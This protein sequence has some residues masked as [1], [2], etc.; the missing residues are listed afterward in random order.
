MINV[1]LVSHLSALRIRFVKCYKAELIRI[2]R[3]FDYVC[4]QLNR[5]K[6]PTYS[7]S[8]GQEKSVG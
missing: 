1:R 3:F 4:I 2:F 5:S 6:L 7:K 8:G